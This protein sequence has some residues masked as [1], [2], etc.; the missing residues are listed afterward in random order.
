MHRSDRIWT[1]CQEEEE[2]SSRHRIVACTYCKACKSDVLQFWLIRKIVKQSRERSWPR[3][4]FGRAS[5]R[6]CRHAEKGALFADKSQSNV[7]RN[8]LKSFLT[9]VI[10]YRINCRLVLGFP[11]WLYSATLF[12]VQ[13][14]RFSFFSF[15]G[16]FLKIFSIFCSLGFIG[17]S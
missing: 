10:F 1:G 8:K 12:S 11:D 4:F 15:S 17:F 16:F 5:I 2:E 13:S 9:G 7:S 3:R 14:T 6:W